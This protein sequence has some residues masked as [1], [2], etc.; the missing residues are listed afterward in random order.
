MLS[1]K[2]TLIGF[3]KAITEANNV[4]NSEKTSDK[5]L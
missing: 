2:I 4:P 5:N 3:G 1:F